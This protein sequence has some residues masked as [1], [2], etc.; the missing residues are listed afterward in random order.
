MLISSLIA[1]GSGQQ[2][3]ADYASSCIDG[4]LPQHHLLSGESLE[5]EAVTLIGLITTCALL[6]FLAAFSGFTR[7]PLQAV[8]ALCGVALT[9]F[10]AADV[11]LLGSTFDVLFSSPSLPPIDESIQLH[12]SFSLGIAMMAALA[13]CLWLG[14]L[15]NRDVKLATSMALIVLVTAGAEAIGARRRSELLST[16]L[17]WQGLSLTPLQLPASPQLAQLHVSL[18]GPGIDFHLGPK[19]LRNADGSPPTLA[20]DY[21]S[22]SNNGL[23]DEKG[24]LCAGTAPP[25]IL[26]TADATVAAL[27]STLVELGARNAETVVLIGERRSAARTGRFEPLL[28][29][30]RVLERFMVVR[31]NPS[32]CLEDPPVVG[33]DFEIAESADVT[34]LASFL[35]AAAAANAGH[36]ALAPRLGP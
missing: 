16:Q 20:P 5:L 3:V 1:W 9:A 33:T 23:R 19:G 27:N 13:A 34:D 36:R 12:D 24:R 15:W 10:I 11:W 8:T 28:R 4:P 17:R 6:L 32:R 29:A 18:T 35:R 7:N 25:V 2:L 21:G 14:A 31:L 26:L 22:L 30:T